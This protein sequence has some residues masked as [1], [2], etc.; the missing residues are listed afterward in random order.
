MEEYDVLVVGAGSGMIIASNAV[1]SGLKTAIAEHGPMGGTCLNR[2][3]IPSKMLLHPAD[4]ITM[5]RE[6]EELG[7]N[8]T[9]NFIDFKKIMSRM[10][11]TVTEDSQLQGRAVENAPKIKWY[12]DTGEFV[13]DYTLQVGDRT[14]KAEKIFIV[15]GARPNVPPIKG[16]E[17]V[18]YLTSDTL[19]QLEEPPKNLVIVGGGYIAAEYGHFF[20]AMG[21]KVTILQRNPQLVPE[22][23]PEISDLLKEEMEKR[24]D[25]FTDHEVIEV[26]EENGTKI[27]TAKNRSNGKLKEFSA[28]SLLLAAGRTPNAD[29]LK[30]EKTGVE[31]NEKGFVKVDEYLETSKKNIWAFGDAIGKQMFKHVANYEADIAWHNSVHEH[32]V[33]ADYAV[34]PHAVFSHP[35]IASVGFTEKQAKEQGYKILVGKEYYKN[36]AKGI[37]MGSP[38]G[39]VKVVIEQETGKILGSHIIGPFAPILIQE[40]IN[41]M[42]FE[43]NT[44]TN[45]IRPM[46]IHPAMPEVVQRA[47]GSLRKA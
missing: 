20:A 40:I 9:V 21:T 17:K 45:I 30:P 16:I 10:R 32:K 2:G 22:E 7:I 47:F 15:S 36:T 46:H 37:A 35:Q 44:F 28:Q 6:A 3:C 19:L 11:H 39:F 8:A 42:N 33:A 14:I 23:E 41:V 27:V 38:R 18:G 29:L 4:I 13:S 43:N 25:V 34:A 26:K 1:T 12:K 31:L 5:V 24:M